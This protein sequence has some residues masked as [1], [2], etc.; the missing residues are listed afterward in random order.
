MR[1][2]KHLV[3][4]RVRPDGVTQTWVRSLTPSDKMTWKHEAAQRKRL[5]LE[6]EATL[7]AAGPLSK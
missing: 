7:S 2:K 3:Y 6:W 4:K 5:D 1:Q